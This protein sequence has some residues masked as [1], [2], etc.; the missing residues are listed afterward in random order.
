MGTPGTLLVDFF[1]L[2]LFTLEI[3]FPD[4]SQQAV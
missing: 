1:F 4:I 3:S 2:S